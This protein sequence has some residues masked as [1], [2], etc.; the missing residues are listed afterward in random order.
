MSGQQIERAFVPVST[1]TTV[2]I[3]HHNAILLVTASTGIVTITVPAASTMPIGFQVTVVRATGSTYNVQVSGGYSQ[4]LTA[5]DPQRSIACDGSALWSML[6]GGAGGGGGTP[7]AHASS[8]AIGAADTVFPSGTGLQGLR[9]NAANSAL[10]FADTPTGGGNW[11][12]SSLVTL[13]TNQTSNLAVGQPI[14]FDT[15]SG[16]HTL[17]NYRVKVKGGQKAELIGKLT[18]YFNAG[19]T[20]NLS[21]KWFNVTS[22]TYIGSQGVHDSRTDANQYTTGV[23]AV[24][25]DSPLVDSEYELRIAA[26][27]ALNNIQYL[28][29][30][31]QVHSTLPNA[32]VTSQ[33][34]R[35]ETLSAA[36]TAWTV[37]LPV[38]CK[39]IRARVVLENG[40]SATNTLTMSIN[41]V[42]TG[43]AQTIY[44]SNGATYGSAKTSSPSLD[45]LNASSSLALDLSA[46][47]A[48]G[49]TLYTATESKKESDTSF[50]TIQIAGRVAQSADISSITFTGN[51]TNGI[52]AGSYIIVERVDADLSQDLGARE[53][54]VALEIDTSPKAADSAGTV[55]ATE[56]SAA[57][58]DWT[59]VCWSPTRRLFVAVAASGTGNRV[60]TSPDGIT[61]TARTSAAD[62][63]W[64]SVCWSPSLYLFV[65]VASSGTGN[66]VM[67]SP[68]GITWTSRTSAADNSWLSVCW[69]PVRKIFVAVSLA[70]TTADAVMTSPDGINWTS[71]QSAGNNNWE[72]VCWSTEKG[73]FVAVSSYVALPLVMTSPDGIAWTA[74]TAS[75]AR[76]WTA[77]CWSQE[78]ALFVALAANSASATVM[79]SPDGVNW[80]SRDA[81]NEQTWSD[82]CWSPSRSL[83][84]AVANDYAS[85]YRAMTS[86]DG[87]A[88]T[89][90]ATPADNAWSA[91]CWSP[92]LATFV[93][94]ASSGTG[95]RVMSSEGV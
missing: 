60:M 75:N 23:D 65:A 68:D 14:R 57:N 3:T 36:T 33:V 87:I 43:H 93:A 4:T 7:D 71:R 15:I 34:I 92:A 90:Q 63:A 12:L 47:L 67:T 76:S 30:C 32:S 50:A 31:A 35:K 95:N 73:I 64:Q 42:S 58:N 82:V 88:W 51:Q 74:Q 89:A 40:T 72:S 52:G 22:S 48:S 91:V 62:N 41:G 11:A 37:A 8:H 17:Q 66:R 54:A 59:S 85:G 45:N 1:N 10:E 79:T 2:G 16:D 27:T 80:T 53:N 21:T 39:A 55:W 24:A 6:G 78:K 28:Y 46:S 84:V 20:Q 29:S 9:R 77:V 69:S 86:P 49:T 44:S 19:T 83:F 38:S 61:W 56:T 13:S 25:I 94:V 81:P 5:T 18:A 26:A 70:P